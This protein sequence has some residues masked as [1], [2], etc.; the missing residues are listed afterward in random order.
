M[1][2][3]ITGTSGHIGEAVAERICRDADVVGLDILPGTFTTHVGD[4]RDA[5]FVRRLLADVN[6]VVHVAA[7]LTPH[8]DVRSDSD[9][10]Q[11]NV[12][13]TEVLLEG[14][15]AA[16]VSRFVFTSTTSVY[17][18]TTRAQGSAV[19]VT[20]ELSPNPEDV[21]DRTKLQ[22]ELLCEKASRHGMQCVVLRMSRCFPEPDH[23]MAFY[24]L[25]RGVD[26]RDVADGHYL[27]LTTPLDGFHV[28]NLS[29][30]SVFRKSDC[31]ELWKDPWRVIARTFPSAAAIFEERRWPL[32]HRVDR[33]YVIDKA[34][35]LLGYNPRF[36]FHGVQSHSDDVIC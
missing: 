34:R 8:V 13:G 36:N 2:V 7:L 20:E 22:A 27:A 32:P 11:I 14:A 31:D 21:Y 5:R 33:V 30:Q 6:G 1:R 24:R 23:L 4:I 10:H 18:C 28:F 17:G 19:W 9:F 12:E 3:L 26:H 16:G 25:Y 15:L 29:A 35:E